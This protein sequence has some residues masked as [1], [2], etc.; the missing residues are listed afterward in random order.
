MLPLII[1]RPEPGA[2][3]T[4]AAAS[5]LGLA[6]R[7]VPL[8]TTEPQPWTVPDPDAFDALLLTS[9]NAVCHA[10]AGLAEVAHLPCYTVGAATADAARLHG[11]NPAR[12]GTGGA[13]DLVDAMV[14]SGMRAILWLTGTEQSAI[15]PGP[16]RIRPIATYA[17]PEIAASPDWADA[18]ARPAVVMLHSARAARRAAA[19]AGPARNHLIALAISEAVA[20]A[21]G[22][23]WRNCVHAAQPG[24]ADMLAL[25]VELCQ[26]QR[27]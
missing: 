8:F 4:A 22:P 7:A 15:D 26:T 9:A 21:S 20:T 24:D 16:A 5:A 10:G 14:A 23:G 1:V 2:S 6:A 11:L 18:I 17:A 12:V 13:Q 25:A 3:R 27:P 19:L